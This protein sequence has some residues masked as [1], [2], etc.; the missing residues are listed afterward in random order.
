MGFSNSSTKFTIPDAQITNF[1]TDWNAW[2]VNISMLLDWTWWSAYWYI[3]KATF[4]F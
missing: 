3:K 1:F 2:N 4:Y